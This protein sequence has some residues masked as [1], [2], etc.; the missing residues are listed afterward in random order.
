M[1]AYLLLIAEKAP[2]KQCSLKKS[3]HITIFAH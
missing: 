1:K 2:E 3:L